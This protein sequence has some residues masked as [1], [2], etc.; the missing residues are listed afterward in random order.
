MA[1]TFAVCLLSML[2]AKTA[3]AQA[4]PAGTA[5]LSGNSLTGNQ[6]DPWGVFFMTA[7]NG[8]DAA[9]HFR[10]YGPN[11]PSHGKMDYNAGWNPNA[12]TNLSHAFYL[13]PNNNND[14]VLGLGIRQNGQV[15]IG[16]TIPSTSQ[17]D[18]KLAVSGKIVAQSLYITAPSTWADFVFEPSYEP[19]ALPTLESYLKKNKHLPYIP[20]AKE[21]EAN[22]YNVAEMDAKLLQTVEELTLQVIALSKQVQELQAHMTQEKH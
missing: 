20:S 3:Y 2:G 21:V 16:T 19:M 7:G 1:G 22:G 10:I 12:S 11:N 9:S 14:L 15:Q 18:Y 4:Q 5:Y 13:R 17:T 8:G 6:T